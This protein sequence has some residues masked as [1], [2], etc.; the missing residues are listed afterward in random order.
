MMFIRK[1]FAGYLE[2]WTL[3]TGA[4][5]ETDW[6]IDWRWFGDDGLP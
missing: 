1:A 5:P 4:P 6:V 2:L 3:A